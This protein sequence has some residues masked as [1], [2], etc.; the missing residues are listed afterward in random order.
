MPLE[1]ICGAQVFVISRVLAS[2]SETGH[3]TIISSSTVE[4]KFGR[5][6]F[7]L[8]MSGAVIP[9]CT[10]LNIPVNVA[11][12]CDVVGKVV[13]FCMACTSI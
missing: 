8:P 9:S 4:H 10:K 2:Y 3:P 1:S 6:R 12:G 7:K 5:K 11:K 13:V